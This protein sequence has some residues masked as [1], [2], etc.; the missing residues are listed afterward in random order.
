[1][2]VSTTQTLRHSDTQT[3]RHSDTQY[4]PD[5]DGLRAIAITAVVAFHTGLTAISGGFVGVDIF[6]VL[7]GFLITSLLIKEVDQTGRI[8][9]KEFYARRIRRLLPASTFVILTLILFADLML[10]VIGPEQLLL[11][12]S[13]AAAALFVSNIYFWKTSGGYF[14]PSSDQ[15]PL[16]HTWSLSVEEQFYLFWPLL[17]LVIVTGAR[18]LNIA[19]RKMLILISILIFIVSLSI[20]IYLSNSSPASAFYL[21]PSRAWEL[22]SGAITAF[23]LSGYKKIRCRY[24]V[25]EIL[26]ACGVIGIGYTLFNFDSKMAFPSYVALLPVLC[27]IMIIVSGEISNKTLT[28]RALSTK[29]MVFI[30]KLSYSWYLWH[31]PLLAI[32]K[33]Q[34]IGQEDLFR[35]IGVS[36]FSLF[37]AYITFKLVENPIRIN[38]PWK[39]SNVIGTLWMGALMIGLCLTATAVFLKWRNLY[40][41]TELMKKINFA[42][43]DHSPMRDVCIKQSF[44]GIENAKCIF[45]NEKSN[46]NIIVW[47]DS[48]AD[49]FMPL[50]TSYFKNQKIAQYT[51]AGCPPLPFYAMEAQSDCQKFSLEVAS[52]IPK[53]KNSDGL[54]LAARWPHY[55]GAPVI[56][57]TQ[58]KLSILK[59]TDE[60]L[61]FMLSSL[62]ETVK[63]ANRYQVP[64]LIIA[65]TPELTYI[66]YNC[67][68]RKAPAQCAGDRIKNEARRLEVMKVLKSIAKENLN[69]RLADPINALCNDKTC[70]A[71]ENDRI[72]FRDGDHLTGRGAQ[73]A[74]SSM[75]NE[76]AWFNK[77]L[78]H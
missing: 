35:D 73:T 37:L 44:D 36:L 6:F 14:D 53:L 47:G 30:G 52:L 58:Q 32:I 48:H 66:A 31:W 29:P 28:I 61:D 21:L 8:N 51:F 38:R 62:T 43:K 54:I 33:I 15:L 9:I 78:T 75:E 19:H 57:V 17:I 18:K 69:V 16:L 2:Q 77:Q 63:Q 34:A 72:I 26:T 60:S 23:I 5:I 3:L 24:W 13:A 1:M 55:V 27:T 64:V 11:A 39:F 70:P 49:Q 10:E 25:A 12:R 40:P 22:M 76:F 68:A 50:F 65:P 42:E 67:L 20:S 46:K 71:M 74:L 59:N 41:D 4:R 7:S 56:Q 45:G